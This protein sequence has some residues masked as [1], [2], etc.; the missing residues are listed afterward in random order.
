MHVVAQDEKRGFKKFCGEE[1]VLLLKEHC[2]PQ[3]KSLFT[4]SAAETSTLHIT[5]EI[6]VSWLTS[7]SRRNMSF[8]FTILGRLTFRSRGKKHFHELLFNLQATQ[9]TQMVFIN[10]TGFSQE[11][12][13]TGLIQDHQIIFYPNTIKA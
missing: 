6:L 12:K 1:T 2:I 13:W 3:N 4:L 7:N 5:E 10:R 8:Y 11:D 9:V